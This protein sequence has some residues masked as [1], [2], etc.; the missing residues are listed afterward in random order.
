MGDDQAGHDAWYEAMRQWKQYQKQHGGLAWRYG[1]HRQFLARWVDERLESGRFKC[2]SCGKPA[3]NRLR[4][5]CRK[6]CR[7]AWGK[8]FLHPTSWSHWRHQA[9]QRDGAKR[10]L[11]GVSAAAVTAKWMARFPG[12]TMWDWP[13]E[14]RQELMDAELEVDHIKPVARNPE[15]EFTLGNLRT[16]CRPCHVA[17][18]AKPNSRRD[19]SRNQKLVLQ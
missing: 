16:L 11:C 1:R 17:H 15:L 13:P 10:V 2:R 8:L 12:A 5:Y 18:G 7:K 14:A 9:I 6:A 3:A 19:P 4:F